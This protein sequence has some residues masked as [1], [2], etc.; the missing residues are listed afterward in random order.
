MYPGSATVPHDKQR[1]QFSVKLPQPQHLFLGHTP[2]IGPLR[3]PGPAPTC[4]A[5]AF[6]QC[7]HHRWRWSTSSV[8]SRGQLSLASHHL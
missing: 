4:L 6:Q 8:P 7:E 1:G 3:A 2:S 5:M